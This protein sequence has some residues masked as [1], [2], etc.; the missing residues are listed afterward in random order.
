[1]MMTTN[2]ASRTTA[3]PLDRKPRPGAGLVR[4]LTEYTATT[5]HDDECPAC[6]ALVCPGPHEEGH[7]YRHLVGGNDGPPICTEVTGLIRDD[8]DLVRTGSLLCPHD[9]RARGAA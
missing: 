4:R 3:L 1:M 6:W 5:R 8:D 2:H 7:R 9:D